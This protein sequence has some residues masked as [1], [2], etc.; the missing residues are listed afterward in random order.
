[1][2]SIKT[3]PAHHHSNNHPVDLLWEALKLRLPTNIV[4]QYKITIPT[5]II[6][7]QPQLVLG[8]MS[9][10][11]IQGGRPQ[12]L[13]PP[14]RRYVLK[15]NVSYVFYTRTDGRTDRRKQW[16]YPFGLK[17]QGVK[18][19]QVGKIHPEKQWINLQTF[20]V[21]M[22]GYMPLPIGP[23]QVKQWIRQVDFE[24]IF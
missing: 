8:P 13:L 22:A 18:T 4:V 10:R 9:V 19:T 14:G 24:E 1:M 11:V 17:D 16:Q 2:I 12:Q 6:S 7:W 5:T 15:T 21:N 23:G 20:M 3:T